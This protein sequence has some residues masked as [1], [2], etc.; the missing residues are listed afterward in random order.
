MAIFVSAVKSLV[1]RH[2][3]CGNRRAM[4]HLMSTIYL[5]SERFIRFC[6]ISR[7]VAAVMIICVFVQHSLEQNSDRFLILLIESPARQKHQTGAHDVEQEHCDAD[8]VGGR[9]DVLYVRI[10]NARVE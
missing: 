10:E 7:A 9:E 3:S 8:S 4:E 6:Q 2:K 5:F 1:I